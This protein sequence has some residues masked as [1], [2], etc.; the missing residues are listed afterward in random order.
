MKVLVHYCECL[1]HSSMPERFMEQSDDVPAILQGW[2]T[3]PPAATVAYFFMKHEPVS[4]PL[5]KSDLDGLAEYSLPC[6]AIERQISLFPSTA[7]VLDQNFIDVW[8]LPR[9]VAE[10]RVCIRKLCNRIL[11]AHIAGRAEELPRWCN[12]LWRN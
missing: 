2:T 3:E 10:R 9:I 7:E 12:S 8:V 11:K 1:L 5:M 6:T 4:I